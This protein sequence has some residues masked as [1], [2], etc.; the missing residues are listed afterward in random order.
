M[1][2]IRL[3]KGISLSFVHK[4]MQWRSEG[5]AAAPGAGSQGH[6]RGSKNS[7]NGIWVPK[8]LTTPLFAPGIN[9]FLH[10]AT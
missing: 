8:I 7:K 10:Y 3:S 2:D 4:S 6:Q 9:K 5:R 1:F